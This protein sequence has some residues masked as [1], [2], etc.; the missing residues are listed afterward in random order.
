MENT[1]YKGKAA[2]L[3]VDGQENTNSIAFLKVPCL[4]MPYQAFSFIY[5]LFFFKFYLFFILF[6]VLLLSFYLEVLYIYIMASGLLFLWD[7]KVQVHLCFLRLFLTFYFLLV[8]FVQ[9]LY[10]S[11]CFTSFYFIF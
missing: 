1:Y 3:A 5:V 2:H 9:L 8:R 11:F 4:L 6:Y 10:I 7:S